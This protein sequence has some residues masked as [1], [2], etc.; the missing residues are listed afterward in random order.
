MSKQTLIVRCRHFSW[1]L[2]QREGVWYADGRSNA[3][4]AGRHSLGTRDKDEALEQL[5]QLDL[6]RAIDLGL[7]QR[8]DKPLDAASMTTRLLELDVGVSLYKVHLARPAV[9]GGVR[10][11]TQKRYRAVLNKFAPYARQ[12]NVETWN[13]VSESIVL[14]YAAHLDEKGYARKT[15]HNELTTIKQ[16]YRWLITAGHLVGCKPLDLP[17]RK[18]ES[19]PAYCYR[20]NEVQEIIKFLE[21]R[22]D[23][24]WLNQV[25]VTLACTGLRIG[26]LVSLRWT[27]VC[28]ENSILTLTDETG[29]KA[30][31]S[32]KRRQ[33]KSGRSRSFPI[34]T[35]LVEVLRSMKRDCDGYLFHGPRGGRLKADTVRTI[36]LREVI[37]PLSSNFP[38]I[39]G[40]RSFEEG[41]LHSF[42][43]YFCSTCA[44]NGVPIRIV[45]KWLGHQDSSMVN[46]YYHLH[47][48][49]AKAQMN[50]L[51]L[52]GS[53]RGRSMDGDQH[54]PANGEAVQEVEAHADGKS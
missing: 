25:V 27:D 48:D 28:L 44:N 46:R 21:K 13:S 36:F 52:L 30:N 50:R 10:E 11:S 31:P 29:H 23:L 1:R 49:E 14:Q 43:H 51:N 3:V 9:A 6:V 2:Y 39:N 5:H 38:A 18:A 4:K 47:N 54:Q 34:H 15:Q 16:A 22:P 37:E 32:G 41:R 53:P 26:E 40:E 7:V 17:L 8:D 19:K 12:K 24:A 35:D 42:R 45:M 20:A 33:T